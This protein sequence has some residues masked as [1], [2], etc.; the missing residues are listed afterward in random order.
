MSKAMTDPS[1]CAGDLVL[2]RRWPCPVWTAAH[3]S[4]MAYPADEGRP[5]GAQ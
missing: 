2:D 5:C 4:L 3:T 1:G